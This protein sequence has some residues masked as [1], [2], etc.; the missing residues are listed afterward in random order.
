MRMADAV[1][2]GTL[3]SSASTLVGK[4]SPPL[5]AGKREV[6]GGSESEAVTA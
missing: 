4:A 1:A 5:A 2:N 3:L 6:K